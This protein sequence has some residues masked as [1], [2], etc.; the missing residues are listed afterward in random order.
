MFAANARAAGTTLIH[1]QLYL[2]R[3]QVKAAAGARHQRCRAPA[4]IPFQAKP[5]IA[6]AFVS[7]VMAAGTLPVRWVTCDKGYSTEAVFLDRLAT[8]GLGYCAEVPHATFVW[9][10]RQEMCVP[11][12]PFKGLLPT[13][14]RLVPGAPRSQ[15]VKDVAAQL[16]ATISS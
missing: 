11:P 15:A 2:P 4:A 1:R 7:A 8:L 5:L 16:P 10:A 14:L 12:A 6:A 3:P 9:P 13:R